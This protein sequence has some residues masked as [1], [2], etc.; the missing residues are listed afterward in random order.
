MNNIKKDQK[1][2]NKSIKKLNNENK[3]FFDF[4]DAKTCEQSKDR[5]SICKTPLIRN[6]G[7][8]LEIEYDCG[9]LV[10]PPHNNG[11]RCYKIE[12]HTPSEHKLSKKFFKLDNEQFD[13]ELQIYYKMVDK[14]IIDQETTETIVIVIFF[15][16]LENAD[17]KNIKDTI[18]MNHPFLNQY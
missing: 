5:F 8:T 4:R 2:E 10:M 17:L 15:K 3:I 12:I 6:T 1:T 9:I 13:L 18:V 16:G 14:R 11:Y 7:T